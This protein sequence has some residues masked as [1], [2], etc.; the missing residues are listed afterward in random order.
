MYIVNVDSGCTYEEASFLSLYDLD[1]ISILLDE[2]ND[3]EKEFTHLFN[4]VGIF[5]FKF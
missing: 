2:D 3:L 5:I 1:K 4:E